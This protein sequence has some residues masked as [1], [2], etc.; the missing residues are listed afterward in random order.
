MNINTLQNYRSVYRRWHEDP[1]VKLVPKF[2]VAKALVNHPERAKIVETNPEITE[3][4][5]KEETRKLKEEQAQYPQYSS[6]AAH[7]MTKAIVTKLNSFLEPRSPLDEML[8]LVA[9]LNKLDMEYA[10]KIIFAMHRA[11]DRLAEALERMGFK[12]ETYKKPTE[13]ETEVPQRATETPIEEEL[14]VELEDKS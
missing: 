11:N 7:K 3:R 6:M 9:I 10:E 4:E 8:D 2:S 13:S 5:A 1:R 14:A 12:I